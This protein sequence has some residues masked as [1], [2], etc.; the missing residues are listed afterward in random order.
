MLTE[1]ENLM[2]HDIAQEQEI[3]LGKVNIS[4]LSRQTGKDRKTIRK[5][6]SLPRSD[7]GIFKKSK[8]SKL[9]SFKDYLQSRIESYPELSSVRL[10]EELI[11]KG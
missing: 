4:S 2:L 6:L 1:E 11:E 3:K 7:P 9:D 10:F 8:A 5:Y